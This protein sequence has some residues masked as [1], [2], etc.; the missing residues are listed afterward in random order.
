MNTPWFVHQLKHQWSRKSAPLPITMSDEMIDDLT[1]IGWSP[2]IMELQVNKDRIFNPGEV[3]IQLEDSSNIQSPMRWQ[4]KGRRF[5]TEPEVVNLLYGADQAVLNILLTNALQD[6]KR[7]IYF[8]VTVS[9]DGQLDLENYF[10][11][12]GQ[13]Y[14]VVPIEHDEVLGRVVPSITT[15]RLKLFRFTGLNDPD[16]YFDENIRRMVDNYRN[17]FSHTAQSLARTGQIEEGREL[18]NWFMEQVPFE[19]IPGDERSFI[20]MADAFRALGEY[21]KGVEILRKSE[22]LLLHMITNPRTSAEM[23]RAVRFLDIVRSFYL[24]VRDFVAASEFTNSIAD[25]LQDSSY[26]QTPEQIQAYYDT[27]MG[28]SDEPVVN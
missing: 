5:Q 4:L 23:E 11:L 19:T 3:R 1:I 27:L 14:R 8:A 6:W 21:D 13:A 16:V 20:F 22:P 24:E 18:L 7:P 17:I 15:E 9:P 10:Q 28:L 25:V 2:A 12:E 26:R